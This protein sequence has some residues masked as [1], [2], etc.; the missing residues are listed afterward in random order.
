VHAHPPAA[1]AFTIAGLPLAQ[2]LLPESI[3][4]LG[5]T[6][7]APYATPST[8]GLAA[9]V[10]RLLVNHDTVMMDRHGSITL[11]ITVFEAY[12]RLESLEHTARITLAA[13]ILGPVRPLPA[14]EVAK[15][16]SMAEALGMRTA[17]T[18]CEG[19]TVCDRGQ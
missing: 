14:V 10:E 13:R 3:L 4:V 12:D 6:P 2:C 5:A 8:E 18:S 11:G 17:F 19:C 7:T 9:E 1:V 15:L 16:R